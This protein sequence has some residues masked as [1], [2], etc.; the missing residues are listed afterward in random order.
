MSTEH[1]VDAK[2]KSIG[3]VATQVAVLLL[4]KNTP[5]T[6]KKNTV[7]QS[8]V[9]VI[10][11]SSLRM[12]E[13]KEVQKTYHRHSGYPGGVRTPTLKHIIDTRGK[14]EALRIAVSGMLPKNTLRDK[15]MKHLIIEE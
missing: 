3:R 1:V 15:R 14:R 7:T 2:G 5:A 12:N 11:V 13:K 9:R 8:R 10:N 4:G 6:A